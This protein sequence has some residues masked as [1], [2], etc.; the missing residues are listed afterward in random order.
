[1]LPVVIAERCVFPDAIEGWAKR[2]AYME[3]RGGDCDSFP[4]FAEALHGLLEPQMNAPE[5][6]AVEHAG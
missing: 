4:A 2:E 6:T 3:A 5:Q 1:M